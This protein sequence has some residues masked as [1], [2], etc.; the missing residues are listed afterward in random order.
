M[1]NER[2]RIEQILHRYDEIIA[3]MADPAIVSDGARYLKLTKELADLE[4][5]VTRIH[6]KDRVVKE[7]SDA[8]ELHTASDDEEMRQMAAEEVAALEQELQTI[9]DDL[10]DLLTVKDPKDERSVIMEIRAGAGGE[11]AALF[12]ADLYKMYSAY[13]IS[14]GWKIEYIES[15]DTEI[16][17]YQKLVFSIEGRG[18]YSCFKYESGVHRVQRVP[19][20]ESGGR[21][22]TSTVTVAVLPEVDEVEVNINPADLKIDTYRA[23]GAGGQHI[24]RTDSA[25]RITHLPTGLVVTCQDE[26]SQHKNRAKAMAVLQSRLLEMEESKQTGAIAAERRSQVGTGDRSEKIRTYNYHQGRV[27]DHRIGLTLYRLEEILGGDLEE[28]VRQLT[29]ADR[30]NKLGNAT[31]DEGDDE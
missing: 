17:G 12:V 3:S 11:E 16:G 31:G 25:I 4:P 20:T 1:D 5:V 8:R 26:R 10:E 23:S 30:A 15:N 29:L 19:V 21:V 6:D 28:I 7:L 22:H 2:E 14:K 27:T 24:N 18:A 13:A 9:E